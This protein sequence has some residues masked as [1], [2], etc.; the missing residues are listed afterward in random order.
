MIVSFQRS[1]THFLINTLA[2]NFKEIQRGWVDVVHTP[3]NKWVSN[4]CAANLRNKIYEQVIGTY[5][6]HDLRRCL[7]THFQAY[8]FDAFIQELIAKYDIF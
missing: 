3:K 6:G 1:G 4:V 2:T 7:K 5:A 8:V